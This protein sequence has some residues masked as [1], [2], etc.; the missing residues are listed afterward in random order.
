[1]ESLL[2]DLRYAVRSLGKRPGFTLVVIFTLALGIGAN[3]AIFSVV[4]AVLLSP[5]PYQ[6]PDRL[7]VLWQKNE[8]LSLTQRPV[9]YP[10]IL[11][12]QAQNQVFEHLAAIRGESFSLTDRDEPE[13]VNGLRVSANALSLLGVKPALGRD[14]LPTEEQPGKAS[15]ALVGYGLWQRRYAGNPQIIGQT[16]QLDG[17]SYQVIGVLPPWL[18]Q[19]GITL[20]SLQPAGAEV[21][22]PV[23]PAASEQNRN[24]A[25][26]QVIAR[27]KPGVVLARAQA[28]MDAVTA[29]LEQQYPNDNAN[30]RADVIPL[31]QHL[32]GS[33]QRALWILLGVVGCV[34]LIACANVANL[35][36]A[37]A[38][39]RQAEM[40][41][42]TALGANRW[43]LIRQLLTEC[44]VLSLSGGLLGLFLA[45]QGVAL[46]TSLSAT[47]IPRADEIGIS[48]QV[49]LF[50]LLISVLTGV[51]FG[52]VPAFRASRFQLTE[53]LKEGKKG[54]AGGLRHRRLLGALVVIEIALALVLLTGAGLMIRSFRS[55][56]EVDPG[57]DPRNV[58]A[59]SV[60]LPQASYKDQ[61]L[62]L[63]F[64][65]R[66]LAKIQALPGVQAAGG[67]FRIP[68]TTLATVIFT[69][70]GKPVPAGQVPNADY[71]AVSY[72]YHRA[73]GIRIIQGRAFTEGD[74]LDAPDVVIVNEELARRYWPGENPL[75]K[76]LQVGTELTR[77]REV[78]GVTANAKLTSLEGKTDPAIYVPFPQNSWPNALRISSIAVRT[79]SDPRSLIPAIRQELRS[80]DPSLPITQIRTMEEI[81]ANSLSQRRF[82]TALLVVF[83]LVAGVLAA[84]GI[85]GVMSYTVTQRTHEVGIRMALGAQR[86]DIVKMITGDGAKLALLGIGIGIGAAII[87]TR[88][89]ASLLFSVAATDPL[90]FIA[91][92]LLLAAVT[93]LASYIPA[94][95]AA[96]T[97]PMTALRYD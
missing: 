69:V 26:M 21:W 51:V 48:P 2:Q 12:W 65:E 41:V 25:N 8:K 77:W 76:R 92:S 27:L 52:I 59:L 46:L 94:R 85:Y 14:F 56:I 13:R 91:M 16:L 86:S 37:R 93:L 70:Q 71:R 31:H 49:L 72:D 15:V 95:R 22:I 34:L 68:L 29:R 87:T 79:S 3:T 9:S 57:F 60:P 90:T 44:M 97:D 11:D 67:T 81:M 42:R 36:L 47:S 6:E 18:K 33:V 54:A 30:L 23:V 32:T 74:K 64:Y 24:F 66:A 1:M 82:N 20:P 96:G 5:L 63:Q 17:K 84:V 45:Y 62:Q 10:N 55:V 80:I 61:A 7:V 35:L 75:G 89:M 40:A 53:A 88:L 73:M 19:P 83:A 43:Q 38:A 58:L 78:V 39:A 50:T 4:Q 28:E